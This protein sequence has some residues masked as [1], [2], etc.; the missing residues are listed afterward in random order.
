MDEIGL[1]WNR[2]RHLPWICTS[3]QMIRSGAAVNQRP[4]GVEAMLCFVVY[5]HVFGVFFFTLCL[6]CT[7]SSFLK[8]NSCSLQEKKSCKDAVG[9]QNVSGGCCVLSRRFLSEVAR[10]LFLSFFFF[11]FRF[12]TEPGFICISLFCFVFSLQICRTKV[13]TERCDSSIFTQA[14]L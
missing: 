9:D 1:K 13:C 11:F 5:A 8:V 7:L 14:W 3:G 4:E 10:Q 2:R 6:S 12:W